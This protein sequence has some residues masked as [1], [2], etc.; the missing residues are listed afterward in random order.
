MRSC[1]FLWSHATLAKTF[2][3]IIE[4]NFLSA[5]AFGYLCYPEVA[6]KFSNPH[7]KPLRQ[8]QFGFLP[9]FFFLVMSRPNCRTN[10]GS[11]ICSIIDSI[12]IEMVRQ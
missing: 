12:E 4:A 7:R 11:K 10:F 3:T 5:V 2:Y 1:L 9:F 6:G 8:L